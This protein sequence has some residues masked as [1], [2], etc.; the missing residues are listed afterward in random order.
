MKITVKHYDTEIEITI[1]AESTTQDL[2][3]AYNAITIG[4]GYQQSS[5][6][7]EIIELGKIYELEKQTT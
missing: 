3:I 6:E 4:C 1:P 5:W 7:E 2:L